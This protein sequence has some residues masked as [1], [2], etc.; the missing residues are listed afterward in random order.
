[1]VGSGPAPGD[2]RKTAL[3]RWNS[4]VERRGS[5]HQRRHG[6]ALA[7]NDD[8][9]ASLGRAPAVSEVLAS[10]CGGD[11]VLHGRF[12]FRVET[13]NQSM[14]ECW[15]SP[16]SVGTGTSAIWGLGT[17][18]GCLKPFPS[19][20]PHARGSKSITAISTRSSAGDRCAARRTSSGTS[21][22]T[23]VLLPRASVAPID[24]PAKTIAGRIAGEPRK[25]DVGELL[26]FHHDSRCTTRGVATQRAVVRGAGR[27]LPRRGRRRRGWW[28]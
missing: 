11:H 15:G 3:A 19:P 20:R 16:R 28:R 26:T 8:G 2:G 1:M 12:S 25:G 22:C 9:M 24:V 4:R 5:G 23:V 6:L 17:W 14:P 18:G 10:L 7:R 13:R 27:W 21:R